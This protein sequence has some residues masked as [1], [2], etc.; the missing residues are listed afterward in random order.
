M[1]ASLEKLM[2]HLVLLFMGVWVI[3][4]ALGQKSQAQIGSGSAPRNAPGGSNAYRGEYSAYGSQIPGNYQQ[5]V[6]RAPWAV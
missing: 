3:A 4:A 2:G 6:A 5:S 1:S